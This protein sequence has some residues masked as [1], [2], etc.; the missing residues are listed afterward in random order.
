[1]TINNKMDDTIK[2]AVAKF[3]ILHESELMYLRG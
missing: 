3:R 1:M 2:E